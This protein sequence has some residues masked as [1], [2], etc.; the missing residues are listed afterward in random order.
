MGLWTASS[1]EALFGELLL[2]K[3]IRRR[4][5]KQD[6]V[7]WLELRLFINLIKFLDL[8][9]ARLVLYHHCRGVWLKELQALAGKG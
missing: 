9:G 8:L 6:A 4:L 7:V 5:V 3:R 2:K 1:V